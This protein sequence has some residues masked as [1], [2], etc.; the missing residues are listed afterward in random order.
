MD[1]AP[2]IPPLPIED[3]DDSTR[4]VLARI[5]L[6]GLPASN[7]FTTLAG[8]KAL[9]RHVAMEG[10]ARAVLANVVAPGMI[11]TP[12]G[13]AAGR[14]RSSRER[15]NIPLGRQGTPWEVANAVTFLLSDASSYITGQVLAV[16]GGPSLTGLAR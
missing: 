9:C 3:Q 5:S 4:E 2:R 7:V 11:D 16:D 13:Q 15:T 12:V 1:R 14:S 6:P 10:A 8:L